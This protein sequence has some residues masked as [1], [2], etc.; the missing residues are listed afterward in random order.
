M[1]LQHDGVSAHFNMSVHNYLNAAFLCKELDVV[2]QPEGQIYQ[3]SITSYEGIKIPVVNKDTCCSTILGE[4]YL[5]LLELFF[6]HSIC[7]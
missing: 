7:G 5:T 1:L 2:D 4:K 6:N 3:A